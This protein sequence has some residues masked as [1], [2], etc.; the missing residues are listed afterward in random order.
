MIK[1]ILKQLVSTALLIS[2]FCSGCTNPH[3][4][5]N[6]VETHTVPATGQSVV[7]R[8]E[9]GTLRVLDLFDENGQLLTKIQLHGKFEATNSVTI[10]GKKE[11][12]LAE[13]SF[14]GT[15]DTS[16]R[17]SSLVRFSQNLEND[18]A[19]KKD[20]RQWWHQ[21]GYL[22]FE[23]VIGFD[24]KDRLHSVSVKGPHGIEVKWQ[25]NYSSKD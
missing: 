25:V 21:D 10:I 9:N 4:V 6:S 19:G 11:E 13:T 7:C 16:S 14:H 17:T 3:L 15:A 18:S 2:L 20:R 1:F 23:E 12:L 5:S 24:L 8:Y 22:L